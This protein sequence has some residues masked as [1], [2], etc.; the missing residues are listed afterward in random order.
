MVWARCG[1]CVCVCVGYG[2]CVGCGVCV[3]GVVCADVACVL[4][5]AWARVLG[6]VCAGVACGVCCVLVWCGVY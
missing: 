6:V 5:V 3:L 1:V 4:G 2:V